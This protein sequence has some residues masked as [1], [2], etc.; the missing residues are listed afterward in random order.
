MCICEAN[1]AEGGR[2]PVSARTP[3]DGGAIG[4][5]GEVADDSTG[6]G[7]EGDRGPVGARTYAEGDADANGSA[8]V[9]GSSAES[10]AAGVERNSAAPRASHVKGEPTHKAR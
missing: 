1:A 4:G 8:T 10:A 6:R 9:G 7:A 2:S 5:G 3:A